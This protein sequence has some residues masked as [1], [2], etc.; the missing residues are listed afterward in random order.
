MLRK[1]LSL[2]LL[3]MALILGPGQ[4][5]DLLEVYQIAKRQDPRFS[6][7]QADFRA[8]QEAKPQARALLLPQ[9]GASASRTYTDQ[10]VEGTFFDQPVN[11]SDS[12]TTDNF[13]L[14][15][16]QAVFHYDFFVRLKQAGIN[17]ERAGTELEA[18]RQDL[19][20]RVAEG[21]FNV[22]VA[23]D[24]LVFANAQREAIN[25]QLEQAQRRFDVGL[26]AVTDVREAQASYD[27]AV[28]QQIE[29]ENQLDVALENLRVIIGTAPEELEK[30][31]VQF[32]LVRPDPESID[33]WVDKALEQN[34]ELIA[35]SLSA[36]IAVKEVQAQ[37]AGHYP[38]LDLQAKA[39]RQDASGG[40]LGANKI[41]ENSLTLLLNLPLYQGGLTASRVREARAQ[42]EAALALKEQQQR[43][44]IRQ[45]RASYLSVLSGISSVQALKQA[46][47]STRT[48]A[49]ATQAGFDVGTRTSV[50]V[51]LAWSDTFSAERDYARSRYDYILDL[52]R[53]KRAAGTL[54]EQDLAE[55]NHWL[56]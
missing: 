10:D 49:E 50:E 43:E 7:A 28:A 33:T 5:A 31:A 1:P 30:L 38:T 2:S 54:S 15:L 3:L 19:I 16:T 37:R 26:T 27:L 9:V 22:L 29:A 32:P 39:S 4:A 53:L 12:F 18:A 40:V 25:R 17:I 52:L 56:G 34:L 8:E 48:A 23:R 44:V 42:Y 55:I 36:E 21:Y 11:R 45:T 47:E 6:A 46:L 24:S 51:L 35:S 20:V 14:N 41:D 13:A